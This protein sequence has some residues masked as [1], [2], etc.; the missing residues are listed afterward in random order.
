MAIELSMPV[1]SPNQ[2]GG[3]NCVGEALAEIR[4]SSGELQ[5]F[6]GSLFDQ[7]GSLTNEVLTRELARQQTQQQAERETLQGQIDRLAGLA[8]QLADAMAEQK[9]SAGQKCEG[10]EQG[11]ASSNL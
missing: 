4:A 7:L 5:T 10:R 9:Q 11:E 3:W 8:A 1:E 6:V 2:S